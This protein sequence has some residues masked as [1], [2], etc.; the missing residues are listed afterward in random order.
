MRFLLHVMLFFIGISSVVV[1]LTMLQGR[2]G[3]ARAYWEIGTEYDGV[4]D[5]IVRTIVDGTPEP[6]RFDMYGYPLPMESRRLRMTNNE[7]ADLTPAW[8]PD[9][10]WI[11]YVQQVGRRYHLY[12]MATGGAAIKDLGEIGSPYAARGW[13]IDGK[14]VIVYGSGGGFFSEQFAVNLESGERLYMNASTAPLWTPNSEW[15]VFTSMRSME[16]GIWRLNPATGEREQLTEG[17]ADFATLSPDGQWIIF[18]S[19][20]G[21]GNYKTI[22]RMDINGEK[23][24][25]LTDGTS[26]SYEPHVSPDG[27]WILFRSDRD[28]E[29]ELYK[30]RVDGTEV[31]RLTED[32]REKENLFWSPDGS[33]IYFHVITLEDNPQPNMAPYEQRRPA[34][35]NPDGTGFRILPETPYVGRNE[36]QSPIIDL[37]WERWMPFIF[38]VSVWAILLGEVIYHRARRGA[39]PTW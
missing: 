17:L 4:D 7:I 21:R 32:G 3:T 28:G 14:W 24:T 37:A 20:V 2:E 13:S 1:G 25:A 27:E 38:A 18:S 6:L 34:E 8:S 11:V 12:R 29:P 19:G 26:P 23:M 39:V 35:I 33:K 9:G 30:M 31:M 15:V 16:E 10:K 5:E 22:F 36:Y